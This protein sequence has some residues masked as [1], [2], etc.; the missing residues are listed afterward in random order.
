MNKRK[1]FN[2][3]TNIP[4]DLRKINSYKIV[5]QEMTNKKEVI[6]IFSLMIAKVMTGEWTSEEYTK[7][8]KALV[9]LNEEDIV[10]NKKMIVILLKLDQENCSKLAKRIDEKMELHVIKEDEKVKAQ[11]IF[12]VL[13]ALKSKIVQTYGMLSDT[14]NVSDL[15]NVKELLFFEDEDLKNRLLDNYYKKF[16]SIKDEPVIFPFI[17]K[18]SEDLILQIT[19]SVVNEINKRGLLEQN[20]K[21]SDYTAHIGDVRNR[22][23]KFESNHSRYRRYMHK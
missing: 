12:A 10:K 6:D 8:R 14:E 22:V 17:R 19:N 7:Y 2:S 23:A 3:F 9:L 11:D 16:E 13:K 15:K 5:D 1:E 4:L 20:A 18:G 21:D